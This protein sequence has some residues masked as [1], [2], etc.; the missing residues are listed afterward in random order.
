MIPVDTSFASGIVLLRT[1]T[2]L[3]IIY[4]LAIVLICE[5]I[6]RG[7]RKPFFVGGFVVSVILAA[8]VERIV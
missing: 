8:L 6:P 1:F 2:L 3:A 7:N 5:V 4:A